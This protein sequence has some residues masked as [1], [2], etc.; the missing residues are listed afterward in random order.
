MISSYVMTYYYFYYILYL[1]FSIKL[2]TQKQKHKSYLQTDVWP[3][4]SVS[5]WS[6]IPPPE[7]RN[8]PG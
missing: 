7:V 3:E 6:T 5:P 4:V 2:K 1:K 8:Q